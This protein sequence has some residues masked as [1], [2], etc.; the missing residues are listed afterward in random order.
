MTAVAVPER[1]VEVGR[2]GGSSEGK[3]GVS[4]RSEGN[5]GT[6]VQMQAPLGVCQLSSGLGRKDFC[7]NR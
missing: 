6:T 7:P 3:T 4:M 1:L 5:P 2:T